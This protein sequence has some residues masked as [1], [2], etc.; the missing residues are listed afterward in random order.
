MTYSIRTFS[1]LVTVVTAAC[2]ARRAAAQPRGVQN[3]IVTVAAANDEWTDT[4]VQ[5]EPGDLLV[6]TASGSIK[7]GELLG[8]TSANG[9]QDGT[10]VL[11]MKIGTTHV[12]PVGSRAFV[13]EGLKGPVKLRIH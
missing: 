7:L 4:T 13:W 1:L 3:V 6:C 8:A 2:F 12:R 5:L 10:G 9:Y 11:Q